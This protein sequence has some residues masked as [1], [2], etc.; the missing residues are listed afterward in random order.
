MTSLCWLHWDKNND[1]SLLKIR[2]L[3][4]L[5]K[6]PVLLPTGE[7]ISQRGFIRSAD[8]LP[9]FHEL[10]WNFS[11][12]VVPYLRPWSFIQIPPLCKILLNLSLRGPV[13]TCR[14]TGPGNM[15]SSVSATLYTFWVCEQIVLILPLPCRFSLPAGKVFGDLQDQ[16][17]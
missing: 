11:S 15:L 12:P 9:I 13:V 6:E 17:Y 5:C 1:R 8:T 14:N 4:L 10:L 7:V 2:F 16:L 3:C